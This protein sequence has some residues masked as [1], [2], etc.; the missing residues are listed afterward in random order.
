MNKQFVT[1]RKPEAVETSHNRD[2]ADRGKSKRRSTIF[3]L[4]V[5]FMLLLTYVSL[6]QAQLRTFM[7]AKGNNKAA[8]LP[9]AKVR[10]SI[11]GSCSYKPF[12]EL[13][14]NGFGLARPDCK[15]CPEILE[16]CESNG[17]QPTAVCNACASGDCDIV[18]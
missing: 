14:A 11:D 2:A 6:A 3:S 16:R 9:T 7:S 13:P 8:L 15:N 12:A 10:E 4:V 1:I 17:W 5:A 18:R